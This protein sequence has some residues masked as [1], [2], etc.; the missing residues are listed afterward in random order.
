MPDQRSSAPVFSEPTGRR[1]QRVRAGAILAGASSI[2]VVIGLIAAALLPPVLGNANAFNPAAL[3]R[4]APV[5]SRAARAHDAARSRL[6]RA[7]RRGQ[8]PLTAR[9]GPAVRPRG[10]PPARDSIMAGFY[11]DWDEHS[12]Q[13]LRA[14]L[15]RMDWVIAEWAFIATTGD[16]LRIQN[17]TN[18]IMDL[19]HQEPLAKRP[20]VLLMV[21]NVLENTAGR[22]G[23]V[24]TLRLLS[25]S[26]ARRRAA[27][28]LAHQVDS[29]HLAGVTV[30]FESVPDQSLPLLEAFLDDLRRAMGP[31]KLLT[32]AIQ[33]YLPPAWVKRFAD[34]CDRLILMF[35]DE[36]YQK[37]DPGPVSGRGWYTE[38]VDSFLTVIPP[39]K[40]MMGIGAYGYDW[41]DA[42]NTP[43]MEAVT[44]PDVWRSARE[45][46]VLPM[47]DTDVSNPYLAWT[48]P[49]SV[50]HF[51]WYLDATS[52][53]DEMRI[54]RLRGVTSAA[55]WRLGAEDPS[56]WRMVGRHGEMRSPDSLDIIDPGYIVKFDGEGELLKIES[57]PLLGSRQI[58][59]DSTRTIVSV[60]YDSVP[61]EWIVAR[62]GQQDH[63]IALTF[64]DGP[65]S[66]WTPAILDTLKSRHVTAT[67][68]LIGDQVLGNYSLTRR[69]MREGHEIGNHTFT[70]PNM[71]ETSRWWTRLQ[72]DATA[73]L[74]EAILGRRTILFRTPYLGDNDPSTPD[75][76]VPVTTATA[77]GYITAGLSVDAQDWQRTMTADDIVRN[78]LSGRE[79]GR[80]HDAGNI[81]LLHD[82]GGDRA[83]TV[84]V[85]GRLI[86][87][88]RARG[89]TI[90]SLGKLA[91][92][93]P[94]AVMPPITGRGSFARLV[95]LVIFG[96]VS[97]LKVGFADLFYLA[98]V[99][100]MSRLVIVL[101]LSS[102]QRFRRRR[103]TAD[104]TPPV[105]VVIPAFREEA[106]I[107]PTVKSLLAQD[108]RGT[109]E[110][111]V[112]DDGSPDDTYLVARR[113]FGDDA[114]VRVLTKPNGGKASA[115]NFGIQHALGEVIVALDAD[116]L[117]DADAVGHLVAPLADPHVGA[118]AGNAKVGN[119]I[120]IVTRW[121][122][123]EYI[124]SQNL[125]RRA[126]ALLDC[127]MVV[128]GAIGAWRKSLVIEA[129]GF[130]NDTL[131]EDQDL[132]LSIARRDY[133]VA[134]A[135]RAVAWTEAPDT[136]RGLAKQRFRWSFGTL[137]CAWKHRDLLFR[138]RAGTLGFIA[139][140]NVWIF[141]VGL[142]L[143]APFADLVF[144]FSLLGVV[145][146]YREH[147][148]TYAL[149][150]LRHIVAWYGVFITVDW[151]AATLAFLMEPAEDRRLTWLVFL[152]RFAYRQ[153]MYI[154]V[155]RA[156]IAALRGGLVG[157]GKLERKATV[158]VRERRARPR[159]WWRV[160]WRRRPA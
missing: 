47:F 125:D 56:I 160:L 127:I 134:Y 24:N 67:F 49:D 10:G 111:L 37:D 25:D 133:R 135:D 156:L 117:F 29:L 148:T 115:L 18:H 9:G 145:L 157:W 151:V 147:N 139:L 118:V 27:R 19:I 60:T 36:H 138:P 21:S 1:W 92:L 79:H 8:L 132:T 102:I 136:L 48:D 86:D 87:S 126:F 16:T 96:G 88:L 54:A 7:L 90:V 146:T 155:L 120:N 58:S 22:F 13:S 108:Y 123:L 15:D 101:A 154:V 85:L 94:D 44:V 71:A 23:G 2:L 142:S 11:V 130:S 30:D 12:Y 83:R 99:L 95:E 52:A 80:E 100:A 141:Q 97:I 82:G 3:T 59:Y 144:V 158:D 17:D 46:N 34:K 39:G 68:F 65:D 26:G 116:T 119:R 4:R 20:K 51:I 131:A 121:Q 104:Y 128:P 40:A 5:T 31:G 55:I 159:R 42:G 98:I 103:A 57:A 91:G 14:H 62:T 93:A 38:M 143:I 78:V 112:V 153:V 109:L 69:I 140:P 129:G 84:A 50:D 43:K 124:T 114:R 63:E 61:G 105:S 66:R 77:L 149:D 152:Q 110:V 150:A 64:D 106:V 70:H 45:H 33:D 72:I 76:L 113:A 41:N 75:E 53:A 73:R 137:Q 74:F 107:V 81:V 28:R 89:D 35:Y 122:A 32:Q 6:Y